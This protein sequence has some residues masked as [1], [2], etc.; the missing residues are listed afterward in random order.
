MLPKIEDAVLSNRKYRSVKTQQGATMIE[1]MIAVL[2]FSVG[3]LGIATTQTMGLT[4]TQSSLSRN[5][6]AQLSTALMDIV[7]ANPGIADQGAL[8][9]GNLFADFA[10][11]GASFDAT[12]AEVANCGSAA[13]ACEADEM[14]ETALLQWRTQ[15]QQNLPGGEGR[16]QLLGT[17]EYRVTVQWED[18]KS[19]IESA[20]VGAQPDIYGTNQNNLFV[21]QME[22]RP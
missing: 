17:G 7:R 11:T 3:L 12:Y 8:A 4:N 9:D 5:Y 15:V 21:Y 13:N 19:Q 10:T 20:A 2:I 16:I 1:V 6:A 18:I 14:A 22:F